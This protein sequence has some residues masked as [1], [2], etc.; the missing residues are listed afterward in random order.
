MKAIGPHHTSHVFTLLEMYHSCLL[1]SNRLL[2]K[3]LSCLLS[4]KCSCRL[5][6]GITSQFKEKI[7]KHLCQITKQ[8]RGQIKENSKTKPLRIKRDKQEK[9]NKDKHTQIRCQTRQEQAKGLKNNKKQATVLTLFFL[10][11]FFVLFFFSIFFSNLFLMIVDE[12][13]K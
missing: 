9:L 1:L 2:C 10:F 13:T 7:Q 4:L 12:Q 3:V 5:L 8:T 11:F 6:N